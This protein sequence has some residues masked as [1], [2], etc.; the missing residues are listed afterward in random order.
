MSVGGDCSATHDTLSDVDHLIDQVLVHDTS[1]PREPTG[2]VKNVTF[3]GFVKPT[4][5]KHLIESACGRFAG[6]DP[7]YISDASLGGPNR[8]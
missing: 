2:S 8:I 6:T 5:K 4:T 1:D 3:A 7:I